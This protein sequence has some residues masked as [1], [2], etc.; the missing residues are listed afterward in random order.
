MLRKGEHK[1][2]VIE[3][4]PK[5]YSWRQKASTNIEGIRKIKKKNN[6]AIDSVVWQGSVQRNDEY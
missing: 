5:N 3:I 1:Y 2:S 4:V 6:V